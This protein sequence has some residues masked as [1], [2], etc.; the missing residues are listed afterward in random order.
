VIGGMAVNI[1]GYSRTTRDIDLCV[2]VD[3]GHGM[4][5]IQRAFARAGYRVHH[6]TPDNWD[7][8]GG[9]LDIED[10]DGRLLQLV[11]Y[12]RGSNF[13]VEALKEAL[14]V[15]GTHL[16]VVSLAHLILFKIDAS[17]NPGS[18]HVRDVRELLERNPE[19]VAEVVAACER[20]AMIDKLRS[21]AGDLLPED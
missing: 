18:R 6:E 13:P 15:E 8:L 2:I 1:H 21:V 11:N 16:R 4:G 20:W 5:D 9:V 3:E 19:R 17:T 7:S 14:T 10:A 12:S